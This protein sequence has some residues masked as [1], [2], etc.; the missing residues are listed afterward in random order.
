MGWT[1]MNNVPKDAKAFLDKEMGGN[2]L[3]SAKVGREYYAAVKSRVTD[4]VFAVIAVLDSKDGFGFKLMDETMGPY[5]YNCPDKILK[6]LTPTDNTFALKWREQVMKFR[7]MKTAAKNIQNGN[8]IKFDEQIS[9]GPYG[10]ED[11]FTVSK[12]G[13][14]VRFYME[15]NGM[16]CRITKWNT[17][18]FTIQHKA[19]T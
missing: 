16:L 18:P 3:A 14:V 17:R 13:S 6:L 5:F 8:V 11:T 12:R 15:K 19:T 4:E 7:T 1:Y 2:L 10:Y 9:F